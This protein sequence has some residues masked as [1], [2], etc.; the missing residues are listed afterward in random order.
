MYLADS[1]YFNPPETDSPYFSIL[2]TLYFAKLEKGI[3]I[4]A[5]QPQTEIKHFYE[6]YSIP[7]S[8]QHFMALSY[9]ATIRIAWLY[10]ALLQFNNKAIK[11][12][13]FERVINKSASQ[14]YN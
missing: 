10:K 3:V 13:L 6:L 9:R 12:K 2:I 8:P 14:I 7:Y 5:K 1:G 4:K 11:E